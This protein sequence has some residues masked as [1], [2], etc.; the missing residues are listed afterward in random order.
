MVMMSLRV[1]ILAALSRGNVSQM[2]HERAFD[3]KGHASPRI[4]VD[5]I[6]FVHECLADRA[7]NLLKRVELQGR[8]AGLFD[9]FLFFD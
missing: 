8:L 1:G 2:T 9:E 5:E 7:M 3:A 4:E 6:A